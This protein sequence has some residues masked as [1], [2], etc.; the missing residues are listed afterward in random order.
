MPF[1]GRR[2]G[3]AVVQWRSG[4]VV[5]QWCSGAVVQWCSGA[6]AQWC[7]GASNKIR[8]TPAEALDQY[9][10]SELVAKSHKDR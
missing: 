1:F 6:V 10:E 8:L 4:A 3:G 5:V 7:S 2:S 9:T